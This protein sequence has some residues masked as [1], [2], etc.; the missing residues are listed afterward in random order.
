MPAGPKRISLDLFWPSSPAATCSPVRRGVGFLG[1][2][3]WFYDNGAVEITHADER[4]DRVDVVSRG[5]LGL[6]AGCARCHDHKY[7]PIPTKDY[8]ALAGVFLNTNYHEYPMVPQ[9]VAEEYKKHEKQ[10]ED[11]QKLVGEFLST[12][13]NQLAQTLAFQASK[14][15]QSAWKATGETKT[16]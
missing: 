16:E 11:R 1:Q 5:F 7:D 13:S 3:V 2:G 6:T 4:H 8:Y 12:E 15:M 10:I 14:D 9:S